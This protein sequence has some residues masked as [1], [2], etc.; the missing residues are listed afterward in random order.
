MFPSPPRLAREPLL[1]LS[2]LASLLPVAA[3][4]ALF[5]ILLG[6]G[7]E[8]RRALLVAAVAWGVAVVAITEGLSALHLVT[9]GAIAALWLVLAVAVAASGRQSLPAG[10]ARVRAALDQR[11]ASLAG[12]CTLDRLLVGGVVLVFALIAAV[13]VLCPPNVWDVMEYHLPRVM[14]WISHRSVGFFPTAE[15]DQ[16]ILGPFSEYALLHIDLLWGGDRFVN[17]VEVASF[18][19]CVFGASA[20]A[21]ELGASRRGQLLAALVCATIPEAVLEASGTMNTAVS[22]LWTL[23]MVAFLLACRSDPSWLNLVCAGAAAGLAVL[24]KGIAYAYLPPLALALFWAVPRE[25][26]GSVLKKVPAVAMLALALNLPQALRA[27]DLTGSLLGQPF[28]DGGPFIGFG[29]AHPSFMGM[30]ANVIRNLSLHLALPSHAVTAALEKAVR[31]AI[32][33]LGQDPDDPGS[34]FLGRMYGRVGAFWIPAF[35]RNEITAGNF[36]SLVLAFVAA[37]WAYARARP[38]LPRR[39]LVLYWGGIGGAVLFFCLELRWLIWSSRFHLPLFVL[40]AAPVGVF[41]ER[42]STRVQAAVAVVLLLIALSFATRNDTRSLLPRPLVKTADI[43]H[44]RAELY[45]NDGH[46]A[47]AAEQARLARALD[48]AACRDVALDLYNPLPDAQLLEGAESFFVYPM[49]ALIG[50][51]E[52]RRRI[53]FEGV[54]NFTAKYAADAPHPRACAV[55]CMSCANVPAKDAEYRGAGFSGT[56]FGH[57]VLFTPTPPAPAA[58]PAP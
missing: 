17:F 15:Y 48:D 21:G 13:A 18:G 55:I 50:A 8:A 19:A 5:A 40:A 20:I 45:Y 43:Y 42:C 49:M 34:I 36:A 24:T 54:H 23:S 3:V 28:P 4:G 51:D 7:M 32:S 12:L 53:W 2:A 37:T 33:G 38:P 41:L 27:R 9:R 35:G 31:G 1:I 52:G 56:A 30:L 39:A 26:R 6:E 47:V 16:V 29:V 25:H 10:A 58:P 11:G 14:L 46:R 57:D 22:S 44:P